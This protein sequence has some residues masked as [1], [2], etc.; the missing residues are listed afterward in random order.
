[1][2]PLLVVCVLLGGCGERQATFQGKPASSWIE[3]L[4]DPN[5][6]ARMRAANAVGHLGPA[7]KRAIPRLIE[8][9]D[10]RDHLVRWSAARTLGQF[11]PDAR[12]ALPALKKL[13]TGDPRASVREAAGVAVKA[14]GRSPP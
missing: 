11:G 12:Q 2:K 1:M 5:S 9:L 10:D 13:A 3:G 14:I 8:L 7:G 6:M 4:N